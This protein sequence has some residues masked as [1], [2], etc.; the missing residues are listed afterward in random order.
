VSSVHSA[1]S[2]AGEFYELVAERQAASSGPALT[3]ALAG[4]D[5]TAGPVLE[6]GAGTGRI[7]E[8]IA[9]EVPGASIVATEPA[10]TMRAA[11]TSRV[12]AD[13]GLRERVTVTAESAQDLAARLPR[14]GERF[15]AAVVFGVVGHLDAGERRALWGALGGALPPGAPIAVELMGV[16]APRTIP[17][18]RMLRER[19]GDQVYEWWS[20]GEP[21]GG[22]RM[23]FDTTWKVFGPAGGP[24]VREVSE[25]YQWHTL[26]TADLATESG[27]A[28][29]QVTDVDGRTTAEI[30]I[31]R[32]RPA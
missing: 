14:T 19:V 31:L 24:P 16:A 12:A 29:E 22:D 11:L 6:I 26:C 27:L 5:P 23:R 30:A 21:S 20:A 13:P 25:S 9:R 1:Y 32:R 28:A 4:V 2:A 7:T 10:T 18:V 17:P 8:L 15:C 3:V